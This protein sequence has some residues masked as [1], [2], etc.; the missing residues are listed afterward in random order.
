MA[1]VVAVMAAVAL[2]E[3][4][5][6]LDQREV[7]APARVAGRFEVVLYPAVPQLNAVFTQHLGT[8]GALVWHADERIALQLTG[9]YNWR[10]A[11]T[12]F[13]SELVEKVRAEPQVAR[14]LLTPW[15]VALAV[16]LLPLSA[17]FSLLDRLAS[18]FDV[19]IVGGIGVAGAR[20]SLHPAF[21]APDGSW[22]PAA[23][24]D[25]GAR[26]VGTVAIAAHLRLG[27]HVA[28]RLEVRDV[29]ASAQVDRVNGCSERDLHILSGAG[30]PFGGSSRLSGSCDV[31][32]FQGEKRWDAPIAWAKVQNSSSDVVHQL[33]LYAGV[34]FLF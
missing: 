11:E 3:D 7:T 12:A 30:Q 31:A 15:H 19:G 8:F 17:E 13:T 2:A 4:A 26:A 29:V 5:P 27:E 22:V 16:E 21:T 28:V 20:V 34:A 24:G 14:A 32:S 25:A 18:R 23:S 9:G 10:A 6:G 33:G 1:L